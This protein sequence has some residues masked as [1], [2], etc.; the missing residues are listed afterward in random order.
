MAQ[1]RWLFS[2]LLLSFALIS[3]SSTNESVAPGENESDLASFVPRSTE[4]NILGRVSQQNECDPSVIDIDHDQFTAMIEFH[5]QPG[6]RISLRYIGT[7]G[8]ETG[9]DSFELGSTD[10]R[11]VLGT[12]I[13]NSD[14]KQINVEADG[15]VGKG[16]T[17]FIPVA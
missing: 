8:Q 13:P 11:H 6:D 12:G 10:T 4:E 17:C 14:L 5:G 2:S 3:C 15:R 16:G 1:Y 9:H 7:D